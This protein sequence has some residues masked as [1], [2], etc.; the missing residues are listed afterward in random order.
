MG[1]F[2]SLIKTKKS[3][4]TY[5]YD[6]T[7]IY[8]KGRFATSVDYDYFENLFALKLLDNNKKKYNQDLISLWG[9]LDIKSYID[10]DLGN[11][12]NLYFSDGSMD[13][14][15]NQLDDYNFMSDNSR[16]LNLLNIKYI[17]HFTL[18]NIKISN[19]Y[20]ATFEILDKNEYFRPYVLLFT[21]DENDDFTQIRLWI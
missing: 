15:I 5:E 20:L 8:R 19:L 1:K 12:I 11:T 10:Y 14:C 3:K 7:H 16:K 18:N 4:R 6:Y 13:I 9:K 2:D 17:K 21:K